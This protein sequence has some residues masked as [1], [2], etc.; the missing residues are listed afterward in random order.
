M[1]TIRIFAQRH[2]DRKGDNLT[3]LGRQQI[4]AVAESGTFQNATFVQYY[5]SPKVRAQQTTKIIAGNKKIEIHYGLYPP[6][7]DPQID[8]IWGPYDRSCTTIRDWFVQLPRQWGPRLRDFTY[9]SFLEIAL[10]STQAA[11][12]KSDIDVYVCSHSLTFE[13]LLPDNAQNT[14]PLK[15]ADYIIFTFNLEGEE[16]SLKNSEVIIS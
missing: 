7:S 10:T 16:L 5:A 1:K 3:D 11:P 4:K 8:A 14:T 12:N 9:T 15:C 6:L 13:F 2:G